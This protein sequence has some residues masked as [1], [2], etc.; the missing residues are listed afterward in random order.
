MPNFLRCIRGASTEPPKK[1][2]SVIS[3]CFANR[4]RLA[5]FCL[6]FGIQKKP[7]PATVFGFRRSALIGRRFFRVD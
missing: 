7:W 6:S 1:L 4:F 3:S 5:F 2:I